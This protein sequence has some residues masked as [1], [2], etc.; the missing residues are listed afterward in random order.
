MGRGMQAALAVSLGSQPIEVLGID[1]D[2]PPVPP[3]LIVDDTR[4]R[5]E[6]PFARHA[7]GPVIIPFRR[8][9]S[10]RRFAI[11]FLPPVSSRC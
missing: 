4:L 5:D 11:K 10:S 8:S 7:I 3:D 2:L 9:L 6:I 1:L